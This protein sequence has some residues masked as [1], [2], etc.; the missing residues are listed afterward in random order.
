MAYQKVEILAP[1]GSYEAFRFAVAAGADAVYAGGTRFGA[2][3]Y[4]DNFSQEELIRAIKEAHLLKRRLYLTVNTLLKDEEINELYDYIAPLYE[5]GLDAVIVQ[6]V[7]VLDFIRT[8]FPEMDI[9]ASTQMSVSGAYGAEFM[10]SCG[11]RRVVPARELNLKEIRQIRDKTSLEIECFV[12]GALCYCYSGQCLMSSM[13]GGR[14]GNRGQCAQP[15][16]LPYSIDGRKKY[17]LSPKDI[18]TLEI[19]PDL[20]EAGIDSFKI[21]GRMK[22]PEYVG[23]VT[24]MYRRYTDLFLERGRENFYVKPEDRRI[25]MDLYNRGGFSAGYYKAHNGF[26][27]MALERPN[28]QGVPACEILSQKGRE[29]F[30]KAK[31][32]LNHGDVIELTGGRGNYTVGQAVKKGTRFSVLLQ[33]NVHL[34][35]G[36]VLYRVRNES[37]ISTIHERCSKVKLQRNI[38]GT[39][40]LYPFSPAILSVKCGDAEYTAV[41]QEIAG[42]AKNRPLTKERVRNQLMKT[43]NS[44]FCFEELQIEMDENIFLPVQQLNILRRTALEGLENAIFAQT[45][46]TLHPENGKNINEDISGC[47]KDDRQAGSCHKEFPGFSVSVDTLQQLETVVSYIS[48]QD[49]VVKRVY[50]DIGII[51]D[52]YGR[53]KLREI[54]GFLQ[55]KNI[56]TAAALPHVLRREKGKIPEVI[57]DFILDAATDSVLIRNYEEYQFL[58]ELGFDKKVIL[59]H[60]LYIFNHCAKKFWKELGVCDFTA[61]AELNRKELEGL[62]IEKADMT[63]YGRIPVMISSQCLKKTTGRCSSTAGITDLK[64][65]YG[66]IFPVRN[67]CD[68]CYNIIYNTRPLYLGDYSES[69]LELTPGM[70]NI[71]F[72]LEEK[73]KVEYVL[74]LFTKIFL[75]GD[76]SVVPEFEYTHGHF[77]RGVI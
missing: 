44:H 39:L 7:G 77:R 15:C 73:K 45:A 18:C 19:I 35:P 71:R 68:F 36:A 55:K 74:R 56:E 17:Y 27:M 52:S 54:F 34:K 29:V 12:H 61:P 37:L 25:L 67:R 65:R 32:D 43:G 63:V 10:E 38:T 62:G 5:S 4:A 69:I 76:T 57:K 75:D 16:R 2:R 60:N 40:K 26:D 30:L 53:Q 24:E 21:E 72:T 22:K 64:D 1:A 48:D 9:H 46:R 13:I 50:A 23:A 49:N 33:K 59:D 42:E 66:N 47:V 3:A 28:H 11:V 58:K 51:F 70:V 31:T 14:S 41:S 6:D 8:N 20:I